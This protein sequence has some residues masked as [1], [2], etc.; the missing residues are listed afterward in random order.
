MRRIGINIMVKSNIENGTSN[1]YKSEYSFNNDVSRELLKTNRSL[2]NTLADKLIVWIIAMNTT[3]KLLKINRARKLVFFPRKKIFLELGLQTKSLN[4]LSRVYIE[5]M[6]KNSFELL[7]NFLKL[8]Y[9][10]KYLFHAKNINVEAFL[11]DTIQQNVDSNAVKKI[12]LTQDR[13]DQKIKCENLAEILNSIRGENFSQLTQEVLRCNSINKLDDYYE[14]IMTKVNEFEEYY[15]STPNA[16]KIFFPVSPLRGNKNVVHL[17][18]VYDL[19]EEAIIMNNC[20]LKFTEDAFCMKYVFF[21]VL[22]PERCTL[23]IKAIENKYYIIDFKAKNNKEP[24]KMANNYIKN[25]V[26]GMLLDW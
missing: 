6:D 21:K 7:D 12:F 11:N 14:S 18:N 15:E 5:N 23:Q 2:T 26:D 24:S 19:K 25:W 22:S 16:D 17:N 20:L 13:I 10:P 3:R 1:Y 9:Y 8:S 4:L